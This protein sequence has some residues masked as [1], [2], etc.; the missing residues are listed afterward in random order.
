MPLCQLYASQEE[1]CDGGNLDFISAVEALGKKQHEKFDVAWWNSCRIT[2][3]DWGEECGEDSS[4]QEAGVGYL[5]LDMR[6]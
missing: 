2:W 3:C 1:I 5:E 6:M 4:L